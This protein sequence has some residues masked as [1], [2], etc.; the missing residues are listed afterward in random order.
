MHLIEYV[1]TNKTKS[2]SINIY[3]LIIPSFS[4]NSEESP[5]VVKTIAALYVWLWALDKTPEMKDCF[6]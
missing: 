5:T 2:I 3:T 1:N 6:L 4:Y